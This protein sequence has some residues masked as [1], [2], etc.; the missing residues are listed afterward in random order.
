MWTVVY[1]SQNKSKVDRIL[2]MLEE[3]K[4]I[5]MLKTSAEDDFEAGNM[6]EILVPQTELETAQ[7]I[8]FDSELEA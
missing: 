4:I 2:K 6:F 5:T 3:N 1:M 8:I 7:D